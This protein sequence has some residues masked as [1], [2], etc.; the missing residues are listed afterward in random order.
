MPNTFF[1][2]RPALTPAI[3]AYEDSNPQYAGF[4]KAGFASGDVQERVA[5][6]YPTARPGKPERRHLL[7]PSQKSPRFKNFL[8]AKSNKSKKE[9]GKRSSNKELIRLIRLCGLFFFK[10]TVIL[11]CLWTEKSK[12]R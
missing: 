1:P 2:P 8:T 3:Y 9:E 4:L 12:C 5:Q 7:F 10:I 11:W 6:Q